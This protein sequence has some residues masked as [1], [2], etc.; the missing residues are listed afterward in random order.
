MEHLT[1]PKANQV[2]VPSRGLARELQAEFPYIADKLTVLPNPINLTRLQKPAEFDR[3]AFRHNLGID[4]Q[5]LVG[6]FVALGQFERKGLHFL[7]QALAT[8]GMEPVKLIVVGG[9]PDLLAR[10]RE[11]AE[12]LRIGDRV[13]FVGMQS[14]VRPFLWSS[15][16][17]VFPSLYETF[18]LV[19]YEAAAAGLPIVV[20]QL[21]G[22]EDLLVDGDNG[23]LIETTAAGVR[24]GLERILSLSVAER[25]LM[26]QRARQAASACSEEHFV[27]AWRAFYLRLTH[28][29]N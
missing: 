8:A 15:D 6:L 5:D 21:Y 25:H 23:F 11:Q 27:D 18:S 26:G 7:M 12:K 17:F 14:D 28:Q 9:E 20:S 10:Y 3:Q 22:V 24:D 29:R 4:D 2:V 13:K 16:V 1:Y 19:T